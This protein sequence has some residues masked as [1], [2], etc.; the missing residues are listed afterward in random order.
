MSA[1]FARLADLSE[2]L[3]DV[4]FGIIEYVMELPRHPGTPDFFHYFSNACNTQAFGEFQN[5]NNAGGAS[6]S[7]E[8]ALAKAIGEAVERY[9]SAIYDLESLPL[10]SYEDAS[11]DCVEPKTFALYSEEQYEQPG[12][13]WVPFDNT[14]TVRWT[15][16][17]D[18]LSGDR[19][20]VP[21]SM[22][23]MPYYFHFGSGDMPIGQ[24]I[25]TGM[26]CHC[27]P[28]EAAISGVCEV[29]ERDA[30]MITWQAML[31]PPQISVETLSDENYD[32]VKRFERLGSRVTLLDM[33][34]DIGIPTVLSVLQS[35]GEEVPALVFAASTALDPEEAVCKSLEELAHTRRYCHTIK[36]WMPRI[37]PNPPSHDNITDQMTHLNFWTDHRNAHLADFI[38]QS[39]ERIDFEK[40]ENLS[41]G[42]PRKDLEILCQRAKAINHQVLII[43]LTTPDVQDLGLTVVRALIPGFH[44]LFMS[45]RNRSLGSTRLWE[46]PQ[47]LGYPGINR[48]SGDNPSPHMYP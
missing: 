42:D 16:A 12:F 15:K 46:V 44:P 25:S 22:V 29:I 18:P 2:Y 19:I 1:S 9:C 11:F 3:V 30:L 43:D 32:R 21:A 37:V 28:A 24:P 17:L 40:M 7:R 14:T 4:K 10:T 6:V 41:T 33:T 34:T 31:A 13:M 20:H 26:A 23:Y 36:A 45:Y 8:V 27:S 35:P 47:K 38:F 39:P 5:F 48:E